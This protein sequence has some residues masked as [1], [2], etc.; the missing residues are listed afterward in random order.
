MKN[1][2]LGNPLVKAAI[3][4]GISKIVEYN[5]AERTKPNTELAIYN[6]EKR[7]QTRNNLLTGLGVLA[8]GF[9]GYKG[10]KY[11]RA[12]NANKDQ[13]PQV[14]LA[15]RLRVAMFPSGTKW[16]PDGT[17]EVEIMKVAYEISNNTEL[18]FS[19]IHTSYKKLYNDNLSV[20]LQ[21]ELNSSEYAEFLKVVADT[22]K[23]ADDNE[24]PE[25][26]AEGKL[27][28]FTAETN[29]F[30]ESGD[31]GK[32]GTMKKYSFFT[33]AVATGKQK[34]YEDITGGIF[35]KKK[36]I[37]VKQINGSLSKW[38]NAEE[39]KTM[40]FTEENKNSL[41]SRGYKGYKLV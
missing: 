29:Y 27:V 19:D 9:A 41:K 16:I 25:Y 2:D 23:P 7:R 6:A 30:E 40:E 12:N 38:F 28:S 13:S 15:K 36:R 32:D 10:I 18:K 20:H 8:L 17:N 31:Y 1:N 22:Y 34:N 21:K 11:I 26:F 3:T 39:I 33:N 5:S 4:K 14:Q 24:N 37:E 35:W